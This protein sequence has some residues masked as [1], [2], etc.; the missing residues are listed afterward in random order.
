MEPE[1]KRYEITGHQLDPLIE[2][3]FGMFVKW[4]DVAPLLAVSQLPRSTPAPFTK[5]TLVGLYKGYRREIW[6]HAA[7]TVEEHGGNDGMQIIFTLSNGERAITF[8]VFTGWQ[9]PKVDERQKENGIEQYRPKAEGGAVEFH[10]PFPQYPDQDCDD[11]CLL[12]EGSCYRG[13]AYTLGEEIFETL[14]VD[15]LD[16][17]WEHLYEE[18]EGCE[19]L[20]DD[21]QQEEE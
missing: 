20:E 13:I 4:E 11:D 7:R 21:N 3:E 1:I 8:G 6:T 12:V 18:I 10:T 19:P 2:S 17:M 9:H 16:A 5:D 15:G 14:R